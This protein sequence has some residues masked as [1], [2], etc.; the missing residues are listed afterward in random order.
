M[1]LIDP[2][3]GAMPKLMFERMSHPQLDNLVRVDRLKAE[4]AAESELQGRMKGI[5]RGCGGKR[6]TGEIR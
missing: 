5:L 4:P 3:L 2:S 6:T 1:T